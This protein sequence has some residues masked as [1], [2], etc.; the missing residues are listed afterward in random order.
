MFA[1][2]FEIAW[3]FHPNPPPMQGP[4]LASRARRSAS[5]SGFVCRLSLRPLWLRGKTVDLAEASL[6]F[7]TR[8]DAE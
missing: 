5:E 6:F 8:R 7:Q 2:D 4:P 1:P 3:Q